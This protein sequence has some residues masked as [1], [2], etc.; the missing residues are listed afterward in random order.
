MATF[1]IIVLVSEDMK[2][3]NGLPPDLL[4]KIQSLPEGLLPKLEEF[5]RSL[6]RQRGKRR[7]V[8]LAGLLRGYAMSAEEVSDARR[9][10]WGRF[11]ER[12]L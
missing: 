8:K 3:V 12:E 1:P 4:E 2:S 5:V 11:G 10:M 7:P 6:K 9:E